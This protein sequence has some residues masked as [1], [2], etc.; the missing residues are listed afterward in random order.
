MFREI[1]K[2]SIKMFSICKSTHPATAVE[3][4][5]S[6][7]FFN[8]SVKSLVVVG[9]NIIRIFQLIP[10]VDLS[11]KNYHYTGNLLTYSLCEKKKFLD[12]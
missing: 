4:V 8:Q 9:A 11:R 10:D 3:H 5:L 2:F 1:F 12:S 6:C 7:N